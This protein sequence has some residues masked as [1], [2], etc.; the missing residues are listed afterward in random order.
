MQRRKALRL[1]LLAAVLLL[2]SLV[3]V[4]AWGTPRLLEVSPAPGA[5]DVPAGSVLQLNFSRLMQADSVTVRLSIEPP[6]PG[7]YTWEGNRL[8]FTPGQ[9]W[10][11]GAT[12]Q[13]KLVEGARADRFPLLPMLRGFEA[14]FSIRQPR[15]AFLYPSSGPANIFLFNPLTGEINPL[16]NVYSGIL[17]FDVSSD[18]TAIYYSAGS[19]QGGI[20]IYRLSLSDRDQEH[21]DL[22]TP[23]FTQPETILSCPQ[24]QCRAVDASPNGEYLAYERSALPTANEPAR[25]QVWILPLADPAQSYLA[26]DPN[27]QTLQPSWSS[28]GLLAFYDTDEAAY[29]VVEPG[30]GGQATQRARWPNQTGQ[31]GDWR[32]DGQAY[33]AAEIF[34][35]DPTSEA[36]LQDLER[37]ADSHLLRYSMDGSDAQDLTGQDGIEDAVP[38][39]S[40]D[41]VW[42]AFARKFL[43]VRQWSPGRQLWLQHLSDGE[44]YPLT[45]D[46]LY[47]HYDFAWSPA[48]NRLAF[49]RFN[50]STL[51]EPP[52]VWTID[53]DTGQ[54][55]QIIIGGY[56]PQ[57]VP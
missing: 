7:S 43:G 49:V 52:E 17:D 22:P 15:L 45:N 56:A 44:T 40:P 10:P 8:F 6:I 54:D 47:N 11:A 14:T 13:V 27:H 16:T 29:V 46:P 42:L 30:D 20:D 4:V 37:L 38:A 9:P 3:I 35:L 12:V 53:P 32:P 41:G 31:P 48:G 33:T 24:A 57:W 1:F 2:L 39:Y 28:N 5:T 23:V 55:T 18:G 21:G 34:F 25:S 19:T 50:Q 51:N 26:G 36:G